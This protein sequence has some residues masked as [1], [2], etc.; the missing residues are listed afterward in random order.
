MIPDDNKT[1]INLKKNT[2]SSIKRGT[3]NN[4]KMLNEISKLM[5]RYVITMQ[6]EATTQDV[7]DFVKE[8]LEKYREYHNKNRFSKKHIANIIKKEFNVYANAEFI[9]MLDEEG[10]IEAGSGSKSVKKKRLGLAPFDQ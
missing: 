9:K 2:S 3:E 7:I 10:Y 6:L 8:G 4:D 5:G 1:I